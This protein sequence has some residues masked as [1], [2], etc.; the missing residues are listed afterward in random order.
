M[1]HEAVIARIGHRCVEEA[2]HNQGA[3][4]LVHLVLDRLSTDRHFDNNVDVFWRI[5]A[6]GDSIN[7]HDGSFRVAL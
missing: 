6:D 5:V 1:R 7:I 4:L 3:S 2:V